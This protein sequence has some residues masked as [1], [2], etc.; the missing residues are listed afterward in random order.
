MLEF[1]LCW[2]CTGKLYVK[3]KEKKPWKVERCNALHHEK[4]PAVTKCPCQLCLSAGDDSSTAP[5]LLLDLSQLCSTCRA[6]NNSP[7]CT[8]HS[9]DF[10]RVIK[11][12]QPEEFFSW[13]CKAGPQESA[14]FQKW[15]R[16]PPAASSGSTT[17]AW[18]QSKGR[19]NSHFPFVSLLKLK[20]N[21]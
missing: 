10:W 7:S 15:C 2:C 6:V 21:K 18:Y 4:H 3:E 14:L 16:Q 20:P 12:F 9:Q 5:L 8:K 1:P 11:E 17:G 13:L 19:I